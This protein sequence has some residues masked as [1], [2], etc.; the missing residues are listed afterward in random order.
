ME[1]S[2]LGIL[3]APQSS[4][5]QP[6]APKEEFLRLLVAQLK[7]QDPL[8][9]Q[10]GSEFVAQLAQFAS[11]EQMAETNVR[12]GAIEAAHAFQRS[13]WICK[14]GGARSYRPHR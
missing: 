8:E 7:H 10:E 11:L 4:E 3:N 14:P 13:R 9:P 2:N 5:G 6:E 1:I 12:L